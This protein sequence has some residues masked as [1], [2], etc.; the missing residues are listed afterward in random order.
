MSQIVHIFRKDA[1]QLRLE[2]LATLTVLFLFDIFEP[3]SWA[4]PS[5]AMQV[6]GLV[7]AA[8]A[9]LLCISWGILI[10]RLIQTDRLPGLNQFWTTRPVEWWKLMAAKGLFLVAFL[11]AP[12]ILSQMLLLHLAGFAVASNL[13]LIL[14]DMVLLSAILV[15]PLASLAA[16][17]S[18]FGQT[19]LALLG[20]LVLLV[21]FVA[22]AAGRNLQPRFLSWLQLGILVAMLSGAVVYQYRWRATRNTIVLCAVTACLLIFTQWLLPGSSLAVAGYA[23]PAQ[24]EPVTIA[25]DASP[26]PRGNPYNSEKSTTILLDLPLAVSGIA[27]GTSYGLEGQKLHLEGSDGTVWESHWENANAVFGQTV[28]SGSGNPSTVIS[29]PRRVYD[30]LRGGD[31]S[32][33]LEFAV[34]QYRDLPVFQTIL[35]SKREMVPGLGSCAYSEEYGMID[36]RSVFGPPSR[37]AISTFWDYLPDAAAQPNSRPAHGYIGLASPLEWRMIPGISPVTVTE[38]DFDARSETRAGL[39]L[40]APVSYAGK[41]IVRRLQ[42]QTPAATVSLKD[43]AG[44]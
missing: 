42:M 28:F 1:R 36:C 39:L 44:L 25:I 24:G 17:T 32:M 29:I 37:F 14:L 9:F 12:L 43:L 22:V 3:R 35:A 27:P 6:E 4:N 26:R 15:L 8:L 34:A 11:Y 31:V 20:A 10:I 5:T 16:V 40:G 18:S 30:R 21:V 23:R 33:R 7:S 19:V 13:P 38:A 2:I 41:R